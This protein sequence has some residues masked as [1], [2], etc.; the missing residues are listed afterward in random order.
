MLKKIINYFCTN[1]KKFML[2]KKL[3]HKI[4]VVISYTFYVVYN[5]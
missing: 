1:H 5:L 3:L 2:V 4:N